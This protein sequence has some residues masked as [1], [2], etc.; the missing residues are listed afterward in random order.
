MWFIIGIAILIF[1]IIPILISIIILVI[2]GVGFLLKKIYEILGTIL[3][4]VMR[5]LVAIILPTVETIDYAF[6]KDKRKW[7]EIIEKREEFKEHKAIKKKNGEKTINYYFRFAK[8]GVSLLLCLVELS[9]F[10][11][12]VTLIIMFPTVYII[13]TFFPNSFT[14]YLLGTIILMLTLPLTVC[15]AP[16][17]YR[18]QALPVSF[19][20]QTMLLWI[21]FRE[22]LSMDTVFCIGFEV[23]VY[24]LFSF[25]HA[26]FIAEL[27]EEQSTAFET[28]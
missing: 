4:V 13:S 16:I 11:A 22:N 23:F 12:V 3:G 17:Q 8:H 7:N 20:L 15:M 26:V 21:Q 25:S 10:A 27:S 9:Y 19:L 6:T 14:P 1:I 28:L 2:Y 24:I 18:I 5:V